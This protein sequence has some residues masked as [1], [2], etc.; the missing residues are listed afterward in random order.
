MRKA[1]GE[2]DSGDEIVG[3][4]FPISAFFSGILG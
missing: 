1:C 3:L 4:V 2:D